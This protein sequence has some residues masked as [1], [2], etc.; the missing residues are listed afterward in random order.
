MARTTRCCA[1]FLV[2]GLERDPTIM[3]VKKNPR[4]AFIPTTYRIFD[5]MSRISELHPAPTRP[6]VCAVLGAYRRRKER[7]PGGSGVTC[8]GKEWLY[9]S[10]LPIISSTVAMPIG[11]CN[12]VFCVP[13]VGRA[14]RVWRPSNA[15]EGGG[16]RD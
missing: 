5:H 16:M 2:S 12:L 7:N 3:K 10:A 14:N 13:N 15:P 9:Y 6:A 8:I 11:A 1:R 4:T